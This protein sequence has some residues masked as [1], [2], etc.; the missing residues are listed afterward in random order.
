M[1]SLVGTG[2][3]AADH[4]PRPLIVR[5][6]SLATALF[7]NPRARPA[8]RLGIPSTSFPTPLEQRAGLEKYGGLPRQSTNLES[9]P[10]G[11]NAE[12]NFGLQMWKRMAF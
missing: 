4:E 10:V 3:I 8:E 5:A 7:E 11:L 9:A 1:L 12:R 2:T 6:G